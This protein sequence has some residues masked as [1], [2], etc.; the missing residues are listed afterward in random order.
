MFAYHC[1]TIRRMCWWEPCADMA[2]RFSCPS[3]TGGNGGMS[4]PEIN[5]QTVF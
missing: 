4:D 2:K 3:L 1:F 5:T